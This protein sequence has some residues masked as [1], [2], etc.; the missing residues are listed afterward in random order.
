MRSREK[1]QPADGYSELIRS[2]RA[3]G[4]K[5]AA[6]WRTR[7]GL[8]V[9][10]EW[11]E[12]RKIV[13]MASVDVKH[14]NHVVMACDEG[15]AV[16]LATSIRSIVDANR[17]NQELNIVIVTSE[18]ST[19]LKTKVTSSLTSA[20]TSVNW[21]HV[22]LSA[23]AQFSTRPYLSKMTYARLLLPDV[24]PRGV[25]RALYLDTDVL[26]LDDLTALWTLD[27]QGAVV[28]AVPD[29]DSQTNADRLR[30]DLKADS[31]VYFNAGVLLVDIERWREQQISEKALQYLQAN[32]HTFNAEQDALN[33]VC[34]GCWRPIDERWNWQTF[35]EAAGAVYSAAT[36][37]SIIHFVGPFKP[38]NASSLSVNADL[39][40]SFRNR[41]CF[42]R[43]PCEA[44]GDRLINAWYRSK[45]NL[46]Q[47]KLMRTIWRIA[48][49][50][51]LR[52]PGNSPAQNH[53]RI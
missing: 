1:S 41:T 37:A 35:D 10:A 15:Y 25:S 53:S 42:A 26:V 6:L 33:V 28:A 50:R 36:R 13:S 5:R 32:P 27:L 52:R 7:K 16:P 12:L 46:R 23:F 48:M 14:G 8:E 49:K 45:R 24:L 43:T 38:W 19:H 3:A 11:D 47:Y 17:G 39:Y 51:E 44:A 18:F 22:D 20:S 4:R 30:S 40:N 2:T 31:P 21:V 9:A 29:I 34:S